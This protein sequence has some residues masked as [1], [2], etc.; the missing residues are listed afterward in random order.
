MNKEQKRKL[1]VL[2]VLGLALLVGGTFAFTAFNQRVTNDRLRDNEFEVGGRVHDYYNRDTENKDVFVENYGEEEIMVRIRLSEF[3]DIRKRGATDFEPLVGEA[4]RDEVDTWTT[5]KPNADNINQRQTGTDSAFFNDY[6]NLT[7]GWDRG[8]EFAP[9]YL[10][11]FNHVENDPRAAA[12]GHARDYFTSD[13]TD[14][15]TNGATHP[16]DGTDAYWTED[17][18]PYDNSAGDWFGSQVTH[19]VAQHL[20]QERSPMTMEQWEKLE[21]NEKI[22]D[23]WVVDH[24][25]GWAYWAS[26]LQP[27]ETTSYLLDA[28]QM[29]EMAHDIRGSYYYGIHVSSHLISPENSDDFLGNDSE[30]EHHEHLA[31]F[32]EGVRNN[33]LDDEYTNGGSLPTENPEY[34]VNSAPSDFNF[35]LMNPGRLFTI[36]NQR[37]RYL[38]DMGDGN[39]LIIRDSMIPNVS[40]NNQPGRLASWYSAL[41]SSEPTLES[42]VQPVIIPNPVPSVP[43][44]DITWQGTRWVPDNL[45]SFPDVA[46]DL[47]TIA[48]SGGSRRAFA[49]SL[50]DVTRLSQPDGSFSTYAERATG[51]QG[52]FNGWWLRTAGGRSGSAWVIGSTVYN[53]AG[54]INNFYPS[55]ARSDVGVR[56][57]LILH[58]AGA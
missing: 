37:F 35:G 22:G 6:S 17:S 28:A 51:G 38:E 32:L 57:A 42:M 45:A 31:D 48:S 49:L 58:Q 24:Q 15:V 36:D 27:E 18:L 7:F 11:T 52:I 55:N 46:N 1:G 16:G 19:E 29:T 5:W 2:A 3:M 8:E 23:F 53:I 40:W 33:A 41:I 4:V 30:G 25:T 44:A 54:Q 12:A 39:H 34:D 9:W 43:W 50:A 56:P 14:G 21:N 10:P 26:K 13:A 20:Q 47:T